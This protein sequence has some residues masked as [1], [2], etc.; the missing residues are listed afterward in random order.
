MSLDFLA[1]ITFLV[2]LVVIGARLG[3]SSLGDLGEDGSR[4]SLRFLGDTGTPF[5]LIGALIGPHVL[6]LLSERVLSELS[7]V[8]MLSFGAI[9]FLYGS[10][11]E[12]RRMKRFPLRMYAAGLWESVFTLAVVALASWLALPLIHERVDPSLRLAMS[13]A[14][15]A[16][17]A[18]TAPAGVFLLAATRSVRRADIQALRFFAAIDDLPGL[19][20]FGVIF[21]LSAPFSADQLLEGWQRLLLSVGIGLLMGT[22]S[23]WL[24]PSANDARDNTLVLLAMAALGAGSAALLRLSPLFVAVIAG[25]VFSNLSPRKESAYGLLASRERSLYALFLLIAGAM[26]RFETTRVLWVLVP[27]YVVVRGLAKLAGAFLGRELFL[28]ATRVSRRVGAGLLFQGG[29]PLVMAVHIDHSLRVPLTYLVM[30]TFVIA[31]FIN[32]LGANSIAAAMLK[33]RARPRARH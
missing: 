24:F 3:F 28:S 27:T 21:S 14:M 33:R 12:W 15:G 22:L 16:C 4:S 23:H 18:G 13:F 8:L 17:A 11:F 7:L 6:N 20:A 25:I 31:V 10:H 9:G 1:L 19:V 30:T 2:A 5:I 29:M 32:D 26:F